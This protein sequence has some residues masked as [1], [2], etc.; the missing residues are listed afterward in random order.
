MHGRHARCSPIRRGTAIG[1]QRQQ[2]GQREREREQRRVRGRQRQRQRIG[3]PLQARVQPGEEGAHRAHVPRDCRLLARRRALDPQVR[4][5]RR[6]LRLALHAALPLRRPLSRHTVSPP[7]STRSG[8]RPAPI[9]GPLL[10]PGPLPCA[11]TALE[12]GRILPHARPAR[13]PFSLPAGSRRSHSPPSTST[14]SCRRANARAR[15]RHAHRLH[16]VTL[17]PRTH[18]QPH[19]PSAAPDRERL[20]EK[21]Q[22]QS[23][24]SHELGCRGCRRSTRSSCCSA[25]SLSRFSS[26][27]N[28]IASTPTS[29]TSST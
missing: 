8:H 10:R 13:R 19:R 14:R 25:S 7:P 12:G 24:L 17:T 29:R 5:A 20:A 23:P 4:R 6:R 27:R 21:H 16:T 11:R 9:F 15:D 18:P 3:L 28:S 1:G 22:R 2:F 26:S